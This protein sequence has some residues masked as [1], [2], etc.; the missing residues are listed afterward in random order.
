MNENQIISTPNPKG[1]L[2]GKSYLYH[3]QQKQLLDRNVINLLVLLLPYIKKFINEK[4][5]KT[6][7]PG[8]SVTFFSSFLLNLFHAQFQQ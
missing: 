7:Q 5:K 1:I 6:Y 2:S 3:V 4:T 8:S